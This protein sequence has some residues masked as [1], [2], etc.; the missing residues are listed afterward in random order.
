MLTVHLIERGKCALD[1]TV[2][3]LSKYKD[4]AIGLFDFA[5]ASDVEVKRRPQSQA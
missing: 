5:G 2:D 3:I 1:V 4:F